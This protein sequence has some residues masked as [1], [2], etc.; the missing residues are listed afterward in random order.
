[1][2]AADD[3][4]WT[5][6]QLAAVRVLDAYE[7]IQESIWG[8]PQNAD[9]TRLNEVAYEPLLSNDIRR[10]LTL[11]NLDKVAF[12]GIT[13]VSQLV[14][15]EEMVDGR[16]EIVIYRCQEDDPGTYIIEK[17]VKRPPIGNTREEWRYVVQWVENLQKW[18]VV[19]KYPGS[20]LC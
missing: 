18:M 6:N 12:G 4:G 13:T 10:A 9:T 2:P 1:V 5:A 11:I 3:P 17:G 15:A 16:P 20:P 8:D 19:D 7:E 14:E